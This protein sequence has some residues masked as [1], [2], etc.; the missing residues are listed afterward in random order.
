MER[1]PEDADRRFQE[2]DL[3]RDAVEVFANRG[4]SSFEVAKIGW[5]LVESIFFLHTKR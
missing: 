4:V 1:Y 2:S 3:V 5:L